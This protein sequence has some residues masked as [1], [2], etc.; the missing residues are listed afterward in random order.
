MHG[1][2]Q[3]PVAVLKLPADLADQVSRALREDIGPGDVTA[4]LI[5]SSQ[6]AQ[7]QVLCREPAVI[8]GAAWFDET[9]RQLDRQVAVNW[10]IAEGGHAPANSIVCV[11]HGPARAILTGERTAL[12][13]LQLLSAT[14]SVT[15]RYLEAISGSQCR[16]LDTRKTI[17]G[18]RSAQKYAV[19]CGGGDNHRMGLYDLVLIKENHIAAAGSIGAAVSAARR[20]A[21]ALRVEVEV[22]DLEEL[23]QALDCRVELVM[24]DNFDLPALRAAV[25]LNRAHDRPALLESSGGLTL[26]GIA[27]IAATGVDFI[28]VGALTKNVVA[29][30]L[31]M[32]FEA[33]IH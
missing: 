21:P 24:L 4:E 9:F 3:S 23:R 11:L 26:D 32:R 2:V 30:D 33:P 15:R 27:A 16:I 14:A 10:N 8:C 31:S 12:N 18:L 17:P 19:R 22:E 20:Q 6:Q 29:I 28:S 7:A 1:C 25:A 5:P 13:F